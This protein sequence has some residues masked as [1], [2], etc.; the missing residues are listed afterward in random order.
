LNLSKV[1]LLTIVIVSVSIS[2]ND[3]DGSYAYLDIHELHRRADTV[4]KGTVTDVST[5]EDVRHYYLTTI[6]EVEKYIKNPLESKIVTV[7]NSEQKMGEGVW[8]EHPALVNFSIG[9]KVVVYLEKASPEFYTLVG[10]SQGKF[11]LIGNTYFNYNADM[12]YEPK[13]LSFGI[14]GLVIVGAVVLGIV[15][16]KRCSLISIGSSILARDQ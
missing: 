2:L 7:R 14:F 6:I 10:A 16:W 3:C 8:Y 5:S 1:I 11:T 4:V 13:P 9:E 12:W 15:Y